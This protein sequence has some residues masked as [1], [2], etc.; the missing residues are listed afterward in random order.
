MSSSDS[1]A[2]CQPQVASL[3]F[4]I[5][6]VTGPPPP[7]PNWAIAAPSLQSDAAVVS[8]LLR[9]FPSIHSVTL[10]DWPLVTDP[11]ILLQPSK[12]SRSNYG[13]LEILAPL[14]DPCVVTDPFS[15]TLCVVTDPSMLL[16][17]SKSSR[18]NIGKLEV[19]VSVLA[20]F[21]TDP[22][23]VI[24]APFSQTPAVM[25]NQWHG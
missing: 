13:K 18:S 5:A 24:T 9:V 21:Y 25:L 1:E 11:S 10:R 19:I 23:D 3:S 4:Y 2:S 16:H 15:Q 12:S 22:C 8:P 6:Q 20:P 14:T 17:P 7:S